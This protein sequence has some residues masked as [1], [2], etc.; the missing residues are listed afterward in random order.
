VGSRIGTT[1]RLS[2][3]EAQSC[4]RPYDDD[5]GV[6]T[7]RVYR[8]H[9]LIG[10]TYLLNGRERFIS[11]TDENA[12]PG[13]HTYA[14]SA[15]DTGLHESAQ[16]PFVIISNSTPPGPTP[17]NGVGG[18]DWWRPPPNTSWQINYADDQIANDLN[19]NV[20]VYFIDLF[21]IADNTVSILHSRGRKVICYIDVGSWENDRPDAV[22]YPRSALGNKYAEYP[23]ERWIDIRR[24]DI[25]PIIQRRMDLC[26]AKGFDGIVPDNLIS[27]LHDTGFNITADDQLNFD[28]WVFNEAHS[29]NLSIGLL[30]DEDHVEELIPYIDWA[31]IEACYHFNTCQRYTPVIQ[32][33]KAVFD[34]EY[35]DNGTTLAQ[36]C[37][38]TQA[39]QISGILKHEFIDT[40]RE[41]CR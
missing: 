24:P 41:A 27:Y 30:N 18:A 28:K 29:R 19:L 32:A 35:T 37:P 6:T 9:D 4:S 34:I 23:D 33:G 10:Q 8:D 12:P 39:L 40:Y 3:N 13:D 20:D 36:F 11:F 14:V 17:T 2:W 25:R 16:T 21:R 5:Y 26:R 7:Y 31:M 38:I 22:Q 15:I 1:V